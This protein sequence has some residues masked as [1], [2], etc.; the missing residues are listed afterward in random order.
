MGAD[1]RPGQGDW[2]VALPLKR[3]SDAKSRIQLPQ[4][5]RAELALAMALDTAAAVRACSLVRTVWAVCGEDTARSF[6]DA[7]C[8]VLVDPRSGQLNGALAAAR[9]RVLAEDP[10]A[11]FASVVADL[12]ALSPEDLTQALT[13]AGEHAFSFVADA[14]GTGT[15]LLAARPV[16]RYRPA[17]GCASAERHSRLGAV[18]LRPADASALR[19][20]VDTMADLVRRGDRALGPRT[21]RVLSGMTAADLVGGGLLAL[22]RPP[23]LRCS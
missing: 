10:E 21:A 3:L 19:A 16:A 7:G 23:Q 1:R 20:D 5:V 22:G 17:Y 11:S 18:P 4:R 15:T 14:A 8:R 12:P 13:Q 2:V 9:D 6:E